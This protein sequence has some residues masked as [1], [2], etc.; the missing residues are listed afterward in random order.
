MRL[1]AT[2]IDTDYEET[3]GRHYLYHLPNHT[4]V[5]EWPADQP[6]HAVM[7][8]VDPGYFSRFDISKTALSTSLQKLIEGDRTQRFYQPLGQM[9]SPTKQL[10]QQIFHCPYTGLMQQLYLESKALE[11]FVAQFALWTDASTPNA[12]ISLC[13]HDIEQLHQAK[14]IL[15]QQATHPPS[16]MSLA[17]Q[18]G[19]NDRKLKQGFRHLF[20]AT[21]FGYGGG[22]LA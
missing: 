19:L 1:I 14:E 10:L 17:R 13:A 9:M 22:E 21:V 18:V 16:L 2:D 6:I 11:L 8:Y 4:E 7:V 15:I 12:S 3:R 5:E 20:G